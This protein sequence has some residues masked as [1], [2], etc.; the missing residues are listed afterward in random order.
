MP[1][2]DAI[3]LDLDGT[4]LTSNKEVD[5]VDRATLLCC[6]DA[7]IQII[8]VSGRPIFYVESVAKTIDSRIK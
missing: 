4:L 5:P 2:I 6:L 3:F 8:L 1:G 7:G